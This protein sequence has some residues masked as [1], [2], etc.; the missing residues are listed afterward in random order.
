MLAIC[1]RVCSTGAMSFRPARRQECRNCRRVEAKVDELTKENE[2]LKT[3]KAALQAKL[4]EA[5]RAAKRQAA[6][7]SKDQRVPEEQRKRP[8]RRPGADYGQKARRQPPAEGEP[9]E[10]IT[11]PA[12]DLDACPHCGGALEDEEDARQFVD[13]IVTTIVRRRYVIGRR[14]CGSCRRTV[15]GR[16]PEQTSSATGAAGVMLG[17]TA[18]SLATWLRVGTGMSYSKIAKTFSELGLSVTPGGLVGVV[19]RLGADAETTYERL[20]EALRSSPVVVPDE[21]GWRVEGTRNWAWVYVGDGVTVYDIAPGRGYEQAAAILGQ[22][23]DG[24]ICRDGWA[25]YGRFA[26]ATH[27]TC[28]AHLLRRCSGLIA[29]AV[30]GQARVPHAARRILLDALTLRGAR[31]RSE[32]AGRRLSRAIKKLEGRMDALLRSRA[33]YEPNVKLLNH[34]ASERD[35]LFTF[36]RHEGVPATNHPAERAVR[37]LVVNRKSWGGNK[38]WAGARTTAVLTSV[39]RTATQQGQNPVSVF[40]QL[41]TTDGASSGLVLPKAASP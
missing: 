23:Y 24:I 17:P 26:G 32:I 21:T 9:V 31:D 41:A 18:Q 11:V 22:D 10:E 39:A 5:R 34:L 2:K 15:S 4:D 1:S 27:Q 30:G 36:L 28:L 16:H 13:D 35:A 14:R 38:T 25:A 8:G 6:P 40:Y 12:P 37:P 3:E 20:V 33:T 29:D 19:S 7:F